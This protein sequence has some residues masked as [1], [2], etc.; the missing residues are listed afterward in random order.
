MIQIQ[1]HPIFKYICNFGDDYYLP[2]VDELKVFGLNINKFKHIIGN[3]R[4]S[5]DCVYFMSSTVIN[6]KNIALLTIGINKQVLIINS[7]N[8][9]YTAF[10]FKN[11]PFIKI[12]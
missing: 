9:F 2:A 1:I 6:D 10:I 11:I 12:N 7:L 3:T 5:R 4:S 8:A